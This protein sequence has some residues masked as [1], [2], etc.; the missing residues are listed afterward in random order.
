MAIAALGFWTM[1]TPSKWSGLSGVQN[2]LLGQGLRLP[3]I[4]ALPAELL[5]AFV[6]GQVHIVTGNCCISPWW[7][8]LLF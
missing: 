7:V 8:S 6:W 2:D 4:T 1:G 3:V 5:G